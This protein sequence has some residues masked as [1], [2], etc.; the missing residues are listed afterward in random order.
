[1]QRK[2]Y[3]IAFLLILIITLSCERDVSVSGPTDY[4][5]G[6]A[7]YFL[8]TE[9]EGAEIYVDNRNTGLVTPDTVKWLSEGEHSFLLKHEP[10]LDY[11]FEGIAENEEINSTTYSYYSDSKNFGSIKFNSSPEGCSIYLNDSLLNFKT[12]GI[13]YSLLPDKYKIKYTFPEHRADSVSVFVYAGKQAYIDIQLQDTSVWV[14]YNTSNSFMTDNT[15]NDIIVSD[16][17]E[18]WIATWHNGLIKLQNGVHTYINSNNSNLPNDIIN[19]IKFAPDGNLWIGTYVG[20]GVMNNGIINSYRTS[21]SGLPSNYISDFD[22]DSDGNIWVGTEGGLAKFDGSSWDV[23]TTSNSG[24]PGNFV[25]AVLINDD[26]T[27]WVGTNQFNTSKMLAREIWKSYQA[28]KSLIGDSVA[29]LVI[30]ND[31]KL[32]V[33]L[34][35]QPTKD[36]DGGVFVFESDTL[37]ERNFNIINKRI[38]SFYLDDEN[39][40]WIGSRSGVIKVSPSGSYQLYTANVTGLPINDVLAIA[41]DKDGNMWFGTNGGGLVKYKI[42]KE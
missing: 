36:K 42:W 9:P 29:D 23:Y 28:D 21:N 18:L 35:A 19:K 1:M 34:V 33:G 20:L 32:W 27:V 4:E 6:T 25:T 11:E 16:D 10:F 26:D 7:M 41:K 13:Q 31:N 2:I 3:L 12:P 40:L 38:N 14:T 30:G 39:N 24:I 15:I 22:F 8:S 5:T 17:N 37:I